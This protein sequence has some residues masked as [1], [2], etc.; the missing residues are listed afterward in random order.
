M[1]GDKDMISGEGNRRSKLQEQL[2]FT[3]FIALIESMSL[4]KDQTSSAKYGFLSKQRKCFNIPSMK[5]TR[6]LAVCGASTVFKEPQIQ[7]R[8]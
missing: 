2:V 3:V 6:T 5:H 4:Q 7:T 8:R 1:A